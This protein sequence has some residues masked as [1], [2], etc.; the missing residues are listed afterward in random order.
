M[1]NKF[2]AFSIYTH[3]PDGKEKGRALSSHLDP[4]L[5]IY[6]PVEIYRILHLNFIL[7]VVVTWTQRNEELK[8]TAV[9]YAIFQEQTTLICCI[10]TNACKVVYIVL[11]KSTCFDTL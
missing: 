7:Q 1:V 2:S 8:K 11:D 3:L 10:T 4:E 6:Y 5:T 9:V